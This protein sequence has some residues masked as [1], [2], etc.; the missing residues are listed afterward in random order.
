VQR[1]AVNIAS[2]T[3]R[4]EADAKKALT[5]FNPQGRLVAPDEVAEAVAFLCRDAAS[6]MTGQ[7]IVV[8]GGEVT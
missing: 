7:S 1:A 2:L 4:S 8:A 5:R 6:A 3:G